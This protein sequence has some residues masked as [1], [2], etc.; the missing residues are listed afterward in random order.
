MLN[1]DV[2]FSGD[3]AASTLSKLVARGELNRIAPGVYLRATDDPAKVV[4]SRITEI[5]ARLLPGSVITDRSAPTSRPVDGILYVA[6]EAAPRDVALPGL[7]IRARR[8]RGPQPDDIA[9]PGDIHRASTARGLAENCLESRARAGATP[10]TLSEAELGDWI[11]RLCRT[12]GEDRLQGYRRRAEELAET[13]GVPPKRLETMRTLIGIALGTNNARTDNP[14][15]TARRS[16][17][18][19]DQARVQR[20][21]RLIE[22]L[23]S[24]A[25]QSRPAPDAAAVAYEPFAEAYFS[26]FIEGTEFEFDEAARIV[27]DGEI[28][29]QRPEDAHDVL[30]THRLLADPIEMTHVPTDEAD[31]IETLQR[32]HQRIMEGRPSVGPGV[33]KTMRNQAG[34]TLFVEPTLVEGTLAAGFRLRSELDTAWERAVYLCFV[35]SEVHPFNDG[36]GRVARATMSAELYAGGQ[37]RIIIPTVFRDDYLDGLRELSRR[38]RPEVY[39]KAMR[40]AQDF[41]ASLDFSDYLSMK[42]QLQETYAFEEP[43]S[44]NRLRL[45][46]RRQTS[47]AAPWRR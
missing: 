27:F 31:F 16:G 45:L 30:G 43:N 20:F 23:R 3:M 32:R 19:V 2:I 13:L 26:N 40:Y 22:A 18:P 21:E 6:R 37:S 10:R 42:A 39:I 28:P 15:L 36:N 11:D 34:A 14:N 12:D 4:R 25:P 47:P 24:A 33:L 38:D 8:G 7:T 5:A 29:E 9:L 17:Q 41:T 46:G 35:V 44:P 1:Q